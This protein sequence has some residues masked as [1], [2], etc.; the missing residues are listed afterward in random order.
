MTDKETN[1]LIAR[2][3]GWFRAMNCWW[4]PDRRIGGHVPNYVE[5]RNA[6]FEALMTLDGGTPVVSGEWRLFARYIEIET[7]GTPG[8]Y[9]YIRSLLMMPLSTLCKAFLVATAGRTID[10]TE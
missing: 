10:A 8:P 5:D 1:E 3:C 2:R 6:M 4:M 7:A 9:R